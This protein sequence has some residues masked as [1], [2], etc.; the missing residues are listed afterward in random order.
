MGKEEGRR[1]TEVEGKHRLQVGQVV[2]AGVFE[3]HEQAVDVGVDQRLWR[4]VVLEYGEDVFAVF[5]FQRFAVEL[6]LRPLE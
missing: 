4:G 3:Q 1:N 2:G 5:G 6:E